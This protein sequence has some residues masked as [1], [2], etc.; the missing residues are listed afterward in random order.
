MWNVECRM[1]REVE[2]PK[3]VPVRT[4]AWPCLCR[5]FAGRRTGRALAGRAYVTRMGREDRRCSVS[6]GFL[7]HIRHKKVHK[8]T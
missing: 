4:P 3:E 5:A 6:I 8:D 7:N 2:R 1:E